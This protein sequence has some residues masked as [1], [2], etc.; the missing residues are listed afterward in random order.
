MANK[1]AR[2]RQIVDWRQEVDRKWSGV[3]FGT[4]T[5]RSGDGHHVFEMEVW[6]G[7]LDPQTLRVELY[8][9][10]VQGGIPVRLEMTRL[11]PVA[12]AAGGY[13]YSATVPADRP[14]TDYTTRVMP[15]CDG[16]AIPLEDA[17]ILWKK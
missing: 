13:L 5:N 7:T 12:G 4:A 8:A 9:D 1:G 10:G 14:T 2:A 6:F 3:R 11:H 15:H 16:V 17:R